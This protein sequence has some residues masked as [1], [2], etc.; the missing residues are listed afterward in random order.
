M[1]YS[2]S[3]SGH[4]ASAEKVKAAFTGEHRAIADR[5]A[6]ALR[7]VGPDP[8]TALVEANAENGGGEPGGTASGSD[9]QGQGFSFS[10]IDVLHPAAP[11]EAEAES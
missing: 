11:A 6:R 10:S 1:S 8:L 4:G 3:I 9:G 7:R 2:I 5:T